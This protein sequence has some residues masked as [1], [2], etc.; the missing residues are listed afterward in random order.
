MATDIAQFVQCLKKPPLSRTDKDLKV[1][2]S[3]LHGMEA[4]AG[5]REHALQS[6]CSMVRY[7]FHEG[8]DIIYYQGEVASCWYILLSGSVFI[9]GSMFL[10][11][12]R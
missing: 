3:Y 2:F 7:E 1:I 9:E 5:V 4:L 10:P 8:N 12:S 6:L 11:R